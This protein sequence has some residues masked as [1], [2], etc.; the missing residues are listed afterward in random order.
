[1][2][3]F[4][5]K[6]SSTIIKE[7]LKTKAT[8]LKDHVSEYVKAYVQVAKSKATRGASNAVSGIV[9]GVVAFLFSICFLLFAFTGIAWWIGG[10]LNSPAAGFF[11][12]AGFFLLLTILLFTL[13]KKVIVPLIR[14][15]LI[16]KVYE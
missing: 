16:S 1:M 7:D 4:K 5:T 10:L 3:D 9:I 2:Q 13:R 14:N 11:C 6:D 8:H 12:V 15:A